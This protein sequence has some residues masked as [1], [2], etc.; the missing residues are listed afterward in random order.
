MNITKYIKFLF[1]YIGDR[2]VIKN[3]KALVHS[4]NFDEDKA[5]KLDQ[6]ITEGI[7]VTEKECKHAY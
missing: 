1:K 5:D 4:T 6:I 2:N 7:L 3:V